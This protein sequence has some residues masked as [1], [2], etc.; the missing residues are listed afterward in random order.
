[1]KWQKQARAAVQEKLLYAP[2]P[3]KPDAKVISRADRGDYIEEVVSFQT[4]PLLRVP[5]IV[6]IPK[7]A[8]LPA[9]AMVALHDHGGFYLWGKR[10]CWRTTMSIRC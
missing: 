4:T 3:V 7:S 9:P 1:M 2:A 8:R 5:A 10:S 6:L